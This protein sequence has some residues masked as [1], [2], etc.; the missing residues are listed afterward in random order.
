MAFPL[1]TVTWEHDGIQLSNSTN[2]II[3]AAVNNSNFTL[4]SQL[5]IRNLQKSTDE[6]NYTCTARSFLG[7]H[8]F[9]NILQ[10]E[11]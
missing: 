2:V 3:A 1:P 10:I 11:G 9:G 6:G 5:T 4:M 7:A 8:T